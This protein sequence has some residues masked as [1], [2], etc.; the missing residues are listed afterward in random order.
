MWCS[1]L[2]AAPLIIFVLVVSFATVCIGSCPNDKQCRDLIKKEF[3][4]PCKNEET[5]CNWDLL[6]LTF[7]V[8]AE[9]QPFNGSA[10]LIL[11][12][13]EFD[14]PGQ[15][16]TRPCRKLYSTHGGGCLFMHIEESTPRVE[17]SEL[18][19]AIVVIALE[20]FSFTRVISF[21]SNGTD[22]PREQRPSGDVPRTMEEFEN[23]WAD[24]GAQIVFL[25]PSTI[26]G[27]TIGKLFWWNAHY[28]HCETRACTKLVHNSVLTLAGIVFDA[29]FSLISS[30]FEGATSATDDAHICG[31]PVAVRAVISFKVVGI[32]TNIGWVAFEFAVASREAPGSGSR[33]LAIFAMIAEGLVIVGHACQTT[34]VFHQQLRFQAEQRS[35]A[36]QV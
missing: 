18:V 8:K 6:D 11:T 15:Q 34:N 10:T 9:T 17:A 35:R 2:T 33:G 20:L 28:S 29:V 27:L 22:P 24:G 16:Y 7:S 1:K 19:F 25:I 5:S 26:V 13:R 4:W 32:L 21:L 30:I 12:D 3:R 23:L 31:R 36:T 14:T